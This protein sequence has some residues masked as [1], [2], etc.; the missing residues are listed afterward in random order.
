MRLIVT[1]L[2]LVFSTVPISA[3][4]SDPTGPDASWRSEARWDTVDEESTAQIH[5]HTTEPRFLTPLV[6]YVP[7]HPDV[8][9]PRDFLGY[10]AGAEG[11]LTRPE[12]EYRYLEAVAAVSP[13]VEIREMGL[14]EE[15]R[16]MLLVVVSS[17]E[18]LGRLDEIKQITAAL[19]DPRSTDEVTA[20]DLASRGKAVMHITAGLHSPET[21]S[22]E[23]VMELIYRLAVSEHPDL[24]EIRD[25]VVLL[26]TPV[27]EVDGRARIVEWYERYL[28]PYEN[29]LFMPPTS[30]PYWGAYAF[31]DNNRDGLQMTLALTKHYNQAFHEWHPVYSLDLHESVPLLYVSTGTGP[32]NENVDPIAVTEWQWIANWEITELNKHRLP[33]VWTWGFYTGWNPSY[34]LWVTNNHNSLGRFYETFGNS[35]AR[36]MERD[37]SN[38]RYAG[39]KVTSRQWYRHNPPDAKLTWSLRNN[40]NYMQSGV[41]A[42][43]TLTAR[44]SATM[45]ENFWRKGR[46]SLER[47]RTDKPHAWIIPADQPGRDRTAYLVNQL[48]RHAIEVHRATE[49]FEAGESS[50]TAGDFVV[51]LDQPY[52]DFARSLLA[53]SKFPPD[54][55]Q[56]PYDDVS[57]TLGKIYRVDTRPI[58]DSLILDLEGLEPVAAPVAFPGAV[59]GSGSAGWAI[60]HDGSNALATLRY[61]LAEF[62]VE[63]ADEVFEAG[64]RE[65]PA[66]SLVLA[67]QD[68]LADALN[69]ALAATQLDAVAL[70]ELPDIAL[71]DVDLPR[72]ALYHNWVATQ[73]DG[74]VR[75]AFADAGI[76]YEYINDDDVRAGGLGERF[77]VIVMAHQGR[78]NLKSMIH[79]RDRSFGPQAY[80]STDEFPSHGVIDSSDDITGGIGFE[81]LANLEDFLDGGGTLMLLG[82][83]GLLAT[84]TGLVRNVSRLSSPVVTPGSALTTRVT[85]RDHPIAF[86]YDDVHHVFRINGPVYSVPEHREHW[87]VTQYGTDLDDDGDDEGEGEEAEASEETGDTKEKEP[88]KPM[89]Q[90]GYLSGEEDLSRKGAVL[91]IP[92]GAGG[93]VLLY[94]FNPLHRFLNHGDHN[95][96]FNALLH[97]NDF[98]APVPKEHPELAWD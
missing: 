33:G 22:P 73:A 5:E 66:G 58:E 72:L 70:E 89:L 91:D 48:Q 30:P 96:F 98:P 68:G 42:S 61:R 69:E 24:V 43:L 8:P 23:M 14:T 6:S 19:A 1:L 53:I 90:T 74:W 60:P 95:Y 38:A 32:Y 94:S 40:N 54:A 28:Q 63:A 93:R 18:N 7:D 2:V 49:D 26:V 37:L 36:T 86:G 56:R 9:S 52:G 50:F 3:Q 79:G 78:A 25:N 20:K 15:G 77:D 13:R 76:E 62:D 46:N 11:K 34:L 80:V 97:W 65:L 75:Y 47:G 87:I 10:I 12:D 45:L 41:L 92:R 85:R 71:H 67:P 83:A 17:E 16:R 88:S 64:G 4:S 82:S 35:S 51:K 44:N 59:Q 21:G 81:G 39:K 55:E 57:W 27:T 84:E 31:H 29:R